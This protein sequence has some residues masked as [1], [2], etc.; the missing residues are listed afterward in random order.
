M[1]KVMRFVLMLCLAL[2][3]ALCYAHGVAVTEN[4][5][6]KG[7]ILTKLKAHY[8]GTDKS[9]SIVAS[10]DGHTLSIVF[11]EN[12]GQVV[13]EVSYASGG[14]VETSAIYTPNG[15]N[16]YIPNTGSYVVTFTLSNGDVY[17]GEFEVTD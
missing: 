13:I 14:E 10:I 4:K 17:Y 12:L 15:V 9:E 8:G 1:K 7:P 5:T 16:Y 3:G 2:S 11:L 6:G